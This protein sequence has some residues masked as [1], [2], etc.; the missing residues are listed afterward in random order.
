[1]NWPQKEPATLRDSTLVSFSKRYRSPGLLVFLRFFV[2]FVSLAVNETSFS[3]W[4]TFLWFFVGQ[5]FRKASNK[6]PPGCFLEVFSFIKSPKN[7]PFGGAGTCFPIFPT[8]QSTF[9]PPH[10]LLCEMPSLRPQTPETGCCKG[11]QPE[12]GE[13]KLAIGFCGER[14]FFFGLR[15]SWCFRKK[16]T[17]AGDK[18]SFLVVL[19]GWCFLGAFKG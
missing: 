17:F 11:R 6:S 14:R 3:L 9:F 16:M 1:M 5:I 19:V 15:S 13:M 18:H 2:L 4:L 12:D 10:Q 7:H 8:P